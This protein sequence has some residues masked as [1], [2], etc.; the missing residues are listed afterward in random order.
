MKRFSKVIIGGLAAL[1]ILNSQ[2][3]SETV[4][5]ALRRGDAQAARVALSEQ[6]AGRKDAGLHR[7]QLEGMIALRQGDPDTAI[8]IFRGILAIAPTFEPSRIGLIRA[9]EASG[10]R[11]SAITHARRLASQTEDGH[12]RDQLLSQIAMAEG[13][14]RGGVALRFA[15]LPSSN[16]TGGTT[17]ETVLVGGVPFTLDPASREASGVGLTLGATAWRSWSLGRSWNATASASVDF[18]TFNTALKPDE[19]ELALRLDA[20]HRGPRASVAFG[21]RYSMLFQDGSRARQQAGI[22]MNAA[23]LAAPRLRFFLSAEMLR[24]T[25][26]QADFRNGTRTSVTPGLQWALSPQ[27]ILTAELPM[28]RESARAR[29][30]AHKDVALGIGLATRMSGGLNLSVSVL[31][32]RNAYDGIYPGFTLAR[33]DHVKS[34]RLSISHN[35][36]QVRGLMPELSVTRK[37]QSSNIPLHDTRTTDFALSLSRRF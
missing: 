36:V 35:K 27:T 30:L 3:Q 8:K 16:I 15:L 7:A 31:G 2:A 10:Q 9:L 37:W 32:G 17:T 33:T 4:E 14:R 1:F 22:G 13:A 24:Q 18:R 20:S 6:I 11:S 26:P 29:H 21:P 5:Q 23:Y 34:L 25:Y 28:L 12:L 19:T